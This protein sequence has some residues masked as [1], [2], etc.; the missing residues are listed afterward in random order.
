M[1]RH[2]Y[3]YI[4]LFLVSG[5]IREEQFDN[6]PKGNFEAL[7]KIMDEGYCFFEYKDI[8]WDA[9]YR[10][11]EP[12][13]TE[14][15]SQDGLF[16]VLG[17]MLGE[18]KDGHVNLYSASDMSRYWSWHEDYPRNFDILTIENRYLGNS[19]RIAGGMKYTILSDNIGYVYYEDF[20]R[21]V[22]E[23]NLDEMLAYFAP[24]NGIIFDVRDNGGG[25]LTYAE[26]IAARFTNEKVHTGYIMHKTGPGHNQFSQPKPVYVEP[27][28]RIRWQKPV[29][30]L[31]N[32]SAYSTT[33]EFANIM[34]Y[35]PNAVLIGDRTGGGAGLPFTS[36][37]PNGWGVRFSASPH[38]DAEKNH[39]EFGIEPDIKIDLTSLT[40][41][42]DIIEEARKTLKN[43]Q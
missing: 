25:T 15:M 37:L 35:M 26:R 20:S 17:N 12:M 7:W 19:Y 30:V 4:L 6:S 3:I 36:E 42:D 18:L 22:G 1:T 5:C 32:R 43:M 29:A 27:S 24:C 40:L 21:A 14:D 8:D 2:L 11:Y 10:K 34:R 23:G 41:H 9:V 38:L 31:T 28:N 16:E 33:N 39:I 13:I